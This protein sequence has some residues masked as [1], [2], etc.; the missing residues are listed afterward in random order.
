MPPVW[1]SQRPYVL[2]QQVWASVENAVKADSVFI[3]EIKSQPASF[4]QVH[5]AADASTPGR[6]TLQL[7]GYVRG[8]GLSVNQL[9]S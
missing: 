7:C 5:F 4:L 6:G 8:R 1:R 9:V 2:A 3:T